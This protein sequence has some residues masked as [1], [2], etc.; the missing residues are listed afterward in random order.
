MKGA[1]IKILN[2]VQDDGVSHEGTKPLRMR[3]ADSVG[4]SGPC[5]ICAVH[6]ANKPVRIDAA[7]R[8]G[9]EQL[10]YKPVFCN[11]IQI[12]YLP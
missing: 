9:E 3:G 5:A 4:I 2:Q 10:L 11:S 6:F 7:L 8:M 1:G 12:R